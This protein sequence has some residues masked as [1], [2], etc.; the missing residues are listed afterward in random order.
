MKKHIIL[1]ITIFILSATMN[2]QVDRSIQPKPGDAPKINLK[3]PQTFSLKNGLQV[4]LVENHKLPR[5]SVSLRLDNEP[6]IEGNKAGTAS[7]AGSL[8]GSGTKKY[9]V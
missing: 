3:E 9:R 5:V 7:I 4:L 2:A 8:L 6:F 1:V